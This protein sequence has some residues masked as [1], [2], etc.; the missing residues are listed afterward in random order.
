MANGDPA[1]GCVCC[2]G[3]GRRSGVA[4]NL[5]RSHTPG[6]NCNGCRGTGV[7]Y[8]PDWPADYVKDT[9]EWPAP[10]RDGIWHPRATQ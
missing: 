1:L 8:Y 4:V 3:T 5:I 9:L 6:Y 2:G 10:V 7:W